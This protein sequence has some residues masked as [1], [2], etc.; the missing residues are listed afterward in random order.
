M[1]KK[2]T[3][4]LFIKTKK[5]ENINQKQKDNAEKV[6]KIINLKCKDN[7]FYKFQFVA[8]TRFS[9]E[10]LLFV[11]LYN[12]DFKGLI[13]A[14]SNGFEIEKLNNPEILANEILDYLKTLN[15]INGL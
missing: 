1:L 2:I 11:N 10:F 6:I 3:T 4:T 15:D 7:Y 9:K 12:Q 13:N 14:P 5:M 8:N